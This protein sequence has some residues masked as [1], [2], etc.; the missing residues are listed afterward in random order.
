LSHRSSWGAPT[1]PPTPPSVRDAPA[2]PWRPS[3]VRLYVAALRR[4]A[5]RFGALRGGARGAARHLLG[6]LERYGFVA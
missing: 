2:K 6:G 5:L 3:V 1:W 4:R